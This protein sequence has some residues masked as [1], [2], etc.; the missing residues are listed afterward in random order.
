MLRDDTIT[1]VAEARKTPI[2]LLNDPELRAL[3]TD[4]EES[5]TSNKKLRRIREYVEAHIGKRVFV[6][7]DVK[8]LLARIDNQLRWPDAIEA[9]QPLTD[10]VTS[11]WATATIEALGSPEL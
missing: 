4:L 2:E 8:R 3:H 7:E 10:A 6:D 5:L 9:L 11:R 1:W